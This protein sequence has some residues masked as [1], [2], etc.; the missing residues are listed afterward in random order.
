[1]ALLDEYIRQYGTRL[2]GLCRSLC[3]SIPEAEDLYQ[4]T[5]LRVLQKFDQY[6]PARPFEP[7]LTTICV[8]QYRSL[9]RRLK[10]APQV[11]F[12]GD[13]EQQD[14]LESVPAPE[15]PDYSALYEAVAALP[16]AYRLVIVLFYFEDQDLAATARILGVPEGTVKSRLSRA[17]QKLKEALNDESIP[18]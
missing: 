9:L 6:D 12:S 7:W 2:Y 10:G 14:L 3:G 11:L 13:R 18:I 15:P 8:N 5:W 16:Q 4:D 17:R 1:M